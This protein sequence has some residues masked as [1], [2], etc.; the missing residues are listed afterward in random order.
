MVDVYSFFFDQWTC[1]VSVTFLLG[2]RYIGNEITFGLASRTK[3]VSAGPAFLLT[4]WG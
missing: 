1:I 3:Q 4:L 2:M